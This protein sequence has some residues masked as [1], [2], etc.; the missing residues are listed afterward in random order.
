MKQEAVIDVAFEI[1]RVEC[2]EATLFPEAAT[3]AP[4]LD[5]K[6]CTFNTS[7]TT[8]VKTDLPDWDI[9]TF[10]FTVTLVS[11]PAQ[12]PL[13]RCRAMNSFAIRPKHLDVD[14]KM[15]IHYMLTNKATGQFAGIWR[16][17]FDGSAVENRLPPLS[18]GNFFADAAKTR[19]IIINGWR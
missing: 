19:E 5:E 1:K 17:R 12:T 9:L 15:T 16:Y 10:E 14:A 2:T 11:L 13:A 18:Y 8:K 4:L 6:S 3:L 7:L